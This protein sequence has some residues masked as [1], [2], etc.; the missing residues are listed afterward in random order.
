MTVGSP[1]VKDTEGIS[2][3]I[4]C[5][6]SAWIIEQTLHY[7]SLQQTNESLH[8]EIIVVNN[9]STDSTDEVARKFVS[10]NF[11]K[12]P[13]RIVEEPVPGLTNARK[14]GA[15]TAQ[16]EYI[17]F[18]D[19][20]NFLSSDYVQL[21]FDLMNKNPAI[22]AIG[23]KIEGIS[24]LD[25]P[26]WWAQYADGYA[27]G[28]QADCSGDVSER[29]YLWGAGL[30]VRKVGL[31]N[32]YDERYPLILT[33]RKGAELSSGGDSEICA[34]LLLMG[35]RLHYDERLE[36]KHFIPQKR[37]TEEYRDKMFQG[38]WTSS[39]LLLKYHWVIEAS[40]QAELSWLKRIRLFFSGLYQYWR[41]NDKDEESLARVKMSV[42]RNK[43]DPKLGLPFNKILEFKEFV[44]QQKPD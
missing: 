14:K 2:V 3:V 25:F 1:V 32:V 10:Q 33:D 5:Y 9:N 17:I 44:S 26:Q 6:N 18:C 35:Y 7:L 31:R 21:A 36:L 15:S 27:V 4:C 29:K 30:I 23:G 24:D 43:I 42:S 39:R 34:R 11:L 22:G 12:V 20:D 40:K 41:A 38:H 8:W 19:D 28:K 13:V 37:L 16:F